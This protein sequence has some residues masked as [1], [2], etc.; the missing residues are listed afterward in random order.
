MPAVQKTQRKRTIRDDEY[1]FGTQNLDSAT[2][3]AIRCSQAGHFPHRRQACQTNEVCEA[4][5]QEQ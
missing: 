3:P 1:S 4:M 2:K 5:S